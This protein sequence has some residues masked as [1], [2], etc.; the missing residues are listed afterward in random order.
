MTTDLLIVEQELA[1]AAVDSG[2]YPDITKTEQA[3]MKMLAG[4]ELGLSPLFS[5][6]KLLIIKGQITCMGEVIIY[7]WQ[8]LGYTWQRIDYNKDGE[9][10][11]LPSTKDKTL[12]GCGVILWSPSGKLLT[13]DAEGNAKPCTF[14]MGRA[15]IAGLTTKD[16]WRHYPDRLLWYRAVAFTARDYSPGLTG[17]MVTT[18]EMQDVV[19]LQKADVKHISTGGSVEAVSVT[20]AGEGTV[21]GHVEVPTCPK[22]NVPFQSCQN[23]RTGAKWWAH[24]I[25]GCTD[26]K[27]KDSW[28][29]KS[30]LEKELEKASEPE[31]PASETEK[32]P[33][34]TEEL[35]T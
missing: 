28:C 18:E 14:D 19:T 9:D 4:R 27:A 1:Q 32:V 17:G 5:L 3:V 12:Y 29:N 7:K 10:I 23:K 8:E 15:S 30:D 34:G 25:D 22:H 13:K 33:A 24:M 11:G 16:N 21:S 26:R 20:I 31:A 35:T 6:Q 2:M